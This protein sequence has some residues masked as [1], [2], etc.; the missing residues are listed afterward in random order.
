MSYFFRYIEGQYIDNLIGYKY[1]GG[2]KSI[3]CRC[4]INPF[5]NWLVNYLPKW[6]APNVITIS[7]F[8]FNLFNLILTSYYSGMKGGDPIPSWVCIVCA[9]SYTTYIIFDY[10]DGKQARRLK[11]SS[12][13]GLLFDHG[14]DACTTFYDTIVTGSIIYYN[15][16]YQYLLLYYPLSFTFFINTW[17]E[18]YVGELILPE[19][20]GVAEGTLLIDIFYILSA[21]YGSD[22][23][24]KEIKLLNGIILKVNELLGICTCFGGFLFC[25]K[26]VLG[27]LRKVKKE[28][29]GRAFRDAFIYILFAIT[30][31]VLAFLDEGIYIKEYPKFII[32]SFGFLF[33]KMLGMLQLAHILKSP[34][35]AYKIV[36]L[37][38]LFALLSHSIIFYL[39]KYQLFGSIDNIIVFCFVFNFLSW[40]HFVY[41]CSEQICE[42]L[43]I[44]RF[45]LGKRYPH[46]PSYEEI[47]SKVII[48][49][50][51]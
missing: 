10:T 33:A 31:L 22:F 40:A 39:I 17:E 11:A 25:V 28:K 36:F 8:F 38:P 13:L 30:L 14:T 47:R 42:E 37:V 35:N 6:L 5:C 41:F 3:L 18:Y 48:S 34:Y 32:L 29:W 19:I 16:I 51:L 44:N 46:K 43:N 2:D 1:S 20:N 21:I 12:P 50:N 4:V 9:I 45:S 27:V 15:N 49:E 7:G 24:L 23:Y 26:S